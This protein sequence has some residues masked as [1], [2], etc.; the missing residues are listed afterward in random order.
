MAADPVPPPPASEALLLAERLRQAERQAASFRVASA[1]GHLIGTPL[2]IISGRAALLRSA[3]TPT[4]SEEHARKIE[5]QVERLASEVRRLIDYLTPPRL[6]PEPLSISRVID[7]VLSICR[8]LAASRG[9]SILRTGAEAPGSLPDGL[10]AVLVLTSV[11]SLAIRTL[12]PGGA[13]ELRV[14]SSLDSPGFARFRISGPGIARPPGRIDRLEPPPKGSEDG[15]PEVL[16][17]LSTCLFIA[18]RYNGTLRLDT[19][20]S[21][22][23]SLVYE[24]LRVD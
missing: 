6:D 9:A 12:P 21:G 5:E 10:S 2:N 11:V 14:E 24:C 13:P 18:E 17:V 7:D 22:G 3:G 16:E 8:P 15:Q 23:A 4:Q 20:S 1:I 19:D